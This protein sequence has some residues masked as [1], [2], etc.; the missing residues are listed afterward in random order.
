MRAGT[1]IRYRLALHGVRLS[2]VT[3]IE[4]WEPPHAFADVQVRGPY[5][6]WHHTHEFEPL[7]ARDASAAGSRTLM[8]DTVRY[9]IGFGPLGALAGRAFVR[10]DLAAIFDYR[11]QAIAGQLRRRGLL[12]CVED[13]VDARQVPR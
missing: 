7:P 3:R 13:E 1:L 8:R 9:A 4:R 10:R 6:V 2:W 11:A 12:E 5:A